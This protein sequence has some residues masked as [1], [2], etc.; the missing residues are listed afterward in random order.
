MRKFSLSL[1]L[2]CTGC[3][4]V[5]P[6]F[7]EPAVMEQSDWIEHKLTSRSDALIRNWWTVFNDSKLNELIDLASEQNLSLKAAGERVLAA[8]AVRSIATGQL[9]PQ[10]Q[11]LQASATKTKLGQYIPNTAPGID[12]KYNEYSVGLAAAWELDFWGKYRR[13]IESAD[14]QLA[15]TVADYQDVQVLLLA[16]LAT[17]YIELRTYQ[18]QERILEENVAVQRRSLEIT[19]ARFNAGVVTE[20]DVAQARVLLKDTE[21]RLP[22][23]QANKRLAVNALSVLLGMT[24]PDTLELL[25]PSGQIPS[26]D[27][28]LNTGI[29]A[30]LLTRRPDLRRALYLSAS[31]SA[32]IGIATAE[33]LPSL[34]F[35][36][37]VGL[38]S[39][40]DTIAT[41]A[42]TGG[43]L[44]SSEAF[45]YGIGP[46]LRWPIL[47]YGRLL[48][49]KRL[50]ESRL[51]EL[52]L[53][54]QEAV[55]QAYREVED[56]IITHLKSR[57]RREILERGE[58]AAD[59]A[60]RL[61]NEQYIEG[62]ADY[63]RVLQT[64]QSLL[65][66]QE[67]LVQT[68]GAVA[69]SLVATYRA[70]GGGWQPQDSAQ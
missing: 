37:F 40:G 47:N 8:R 39:S 29:P 49:G 54:Y 2:L 25:G 45:T 56:G 3:W 17:R 67:S 16:E 58:E 21:A 5:G 36:G 63:T 38:Q 68:R 9:F 48:N 4:R 35:S 52:V 28:A 60:F 69:T 11:E 26:A 46:Q 19:T 61:A 10:S 53:R 1:L 59:R 18:E 15:A 44:L 57:E 24:A 7:A 66:T 42:G 55:L 64:Q 13:G 14:A 6:D 33:L 22:V 20:L 62:L 34:S 65:L 70:L 32:R 30:E 43:Q 51:R 41:V 12:L 50:E 31:Q 27:H 23:V